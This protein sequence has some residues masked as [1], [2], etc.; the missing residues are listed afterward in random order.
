MTF[1]LWAWLTFA[2]LV[3]VL[4]FLDLFVFHRG[5][6]EVPF[7]EAMWLSVFWI[8]ISLAFGVV[9]WFLAGPEGAAAYLT[10][11]LLE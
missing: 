4:L 1:P 2:V 5:A 9:V 7:G 8:A 11:Y 3:A 10:A 6:R